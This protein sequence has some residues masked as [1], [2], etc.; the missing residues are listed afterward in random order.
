MPIPDNIVYDDVGSEL[1]IEMD[2]NNEELG[3]V[4]DEYASENFDDDDEEEGD[5]DPDV[6]YFWSTYSFILLMP[7]YS[8]STYQ[9]ASS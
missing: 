2:E 5:D 8:K 4:V 1:N 6:P 9:L 3:L 7:V